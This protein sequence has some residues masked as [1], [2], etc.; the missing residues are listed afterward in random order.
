MLSHGYC[1]L[2][3]AIN[4]GVQIVVQ[5]HAFSYFGYL[6]KSGIAELYNNI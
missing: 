5:V 6:P 2:Y 1:E 3:A 4:I